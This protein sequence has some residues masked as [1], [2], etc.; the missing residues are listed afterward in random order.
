MTQTQGKLSMNGETSSLSFEREIPVTVERVWDL[1][2]RG[3]DLAQWLA[4]TEMDLRVG[5]A[6]RID[7]GDEGGTV[8][9][10]I[11]EVEPMH[12]LAYTWS[13]EGEPDSVV[14]WT[15]RPGGAGTWLG[16]V[17]R[18]LP[19]GYARGYGAGWHAHLDRLEAVTEGR[20]VPD[21]EERFGE[22]LT[23]YA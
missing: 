14:E 3:D 8:I 20:P 2:T 16:L 7:F 12:R 11:I 10:A 1:L 17:H 4:P 18:T 15:L 21:W 6:V 19:A 23:G 22:L 9:G 5:G 13:I